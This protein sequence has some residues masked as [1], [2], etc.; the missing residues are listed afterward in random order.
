MLVVLWLLGLVL[1]TTA[2]AH[3][4]IATLQAQPERLNPGGTVELT[5]DM[6]TEDLVELVLVADAGGGSLVLG[7]A[8]ADYEGHFVVSFLVPAGVPV[9]GYRILARSI[10]DQADARIEVAG[11]PLVGE[12]GQL[13]GQDEA[14]A[15]VQPSAGQAPG[16][17]PLVNPLTPD[18]T[19]PP[20][21]LGLTALVVII[22]V[23]LA[24]G[25]GVVTRARS[26]RGAPTREPAVPRPDST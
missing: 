21:D 22:V 17:N 4:G 26:R 11:P 18:P 6:T 5:G 9:G 24:L 23:G 19:N 16:G 8:M 3:G 14:L 1:P 13:P 20:A 25:I 15:G 12:A 10:V 2:A 7:T